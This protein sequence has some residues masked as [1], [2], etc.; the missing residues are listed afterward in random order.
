VNDESERVWKEAVVG[1]FEVLFRHLPGGTEENHKNLSQNSWPPGRD[2]NPEPP[3]Y[4]V[5]MLTTQPRR[6]VE[7]LGRLGDKFMYHT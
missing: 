5:G 1:Q 2:S 3:E 6:S 7:R 4:K